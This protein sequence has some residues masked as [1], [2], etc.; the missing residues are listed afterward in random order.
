MKRGFWLVAVVAAGT[1]FAPARAD[2]KDT[3]ALLLGKWELVGDA[4]KGALKSNLEFAKDGDIV[5]TAGKDFTV[6][7]KF[8]LVDEKTIEV[9]LPKDS[10][11]PKETETNTATVAVT[12]DEL[13]ITA[14][15]GKKVTKYRRV[16]E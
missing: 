1:W 15:G 13:T 4:P 7:G 3:G 8:R 16:K 2:V 9:T 12:K 10:K 5:L 14:Q 6:K 11:N